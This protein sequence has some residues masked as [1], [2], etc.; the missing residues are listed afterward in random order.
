[1]QLINRPSTYYSLLQPDTARSYYLHF[2]LDYVHIQQL[3]GRAMVGWA[4]KPAWAG[5]DLFNLFDVGRTRLTRPRGS[6]RQSLLN[7]PKIF[8]RWPRC[9]AAAMCVRDIGSRLQKR[10]LQHSKSIR[11]EE[12][13]TSER[14]RDEKVKEGA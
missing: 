3:R 2:L 5:V 13:L 7:L 8:F 12:R 14:R 6:A 4:G 1:M 9:S 11:D 10:S